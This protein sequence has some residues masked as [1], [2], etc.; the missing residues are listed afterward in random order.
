MPPSPP[1]H[2]DEETLWDFALGKLLKSVDDEIK[3]HLLQCNRCKAVVFEVL[4]GFVALAELLGP[5]LP[6]WEIWK[7]EM[8]PIIAALPKPH[9][10]RVMGAD[11]TSSETWRWRYDAKSNT[12]TLEVLE[13]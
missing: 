8:E 11:G 12:Y 6:D 7:A 2:P 10:L 4:D 1:P 5:D 3:E 13:P 9:H